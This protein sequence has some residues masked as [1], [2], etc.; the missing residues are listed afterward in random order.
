MA[1]EMKPEHIAAMDTNILFQKYTINEVKDT[2]KRVRSDIERKK[3]DLRQM[4]GERYRDLIEAADTIR[5]MKNSANN[6][7]QAVS[8]MDKYCQQLQ[9]NKKNHARE[10]MEAAKKKEHDAF[11]SIAA[12]IKLLLDMPER[13]WSSLEADELLSAARLYLLSHHIMSSLHLD[14]PSPPPSAQSLLAFFPILSRQWSYISHFKVAILQNAR[15]MLKKPDATEKATAEAL[16]S[17]V[18]LEDTSPRQVFTEYLLAK[19]NTIQQ[20]C[21]PGQQGGSI[22]AHVCGVVQLIVSTVR[23]MHAVFYS[24]EAGSFKEQACDQLLTTLHSVSGDGAASV[25]SLLEPELRNRPF[26]KHIPSSIAGF[27]PSL[28]TLANP[29]SQEHLQASCQQ[30]IT[31]CVETIHRGVG[32]LL[33]YVSTIKGLV[34]IRDAVW[35]MLAQDGAGTEWNEVCQHILHREVQVWEEFLRPILLNRSQVIIE[36]QCSSTAELS[37]QL[38]TNTLQELGQKNSTERTLMSEHDVAGYVWTEMSSDMPSRSSWFHNKTGEEMGGLAMKAKAFTPRVQSLCKKMDNKLESLLEDMSQ[39]TSV[40]RHQQDISAG[41]DSS[42]DSPP[43]DKFADNVHLEKYLQNGCASCV[44]RL[45]ECVSAELKSAR[46]V[47]LNK[48]AVGMSDSSSTIDKALFLARLCFGLVEICPNLQLCMMGKQLKD[49]AQDSARV[50][51]KQ[52][53]WR[54]VSKMQG[55]MPPLDEN[56]PWGKLR[57]QLFATAEIGHR[58]WAEHTSGWLVD[59]F[60]SALRDSSP[61]AL[62]MSATNWEEMEIQEETEAGKSVQ[63][64][65]RLPAQASWYVQSM[66][67][68]LCR[69]VNRVGGHALSRSII[70]EVVQQTCAGVL[71]AYEALLQ[72]SATLPQARALQLVFDLRYI[73]NMLS[74]RGPDSQAY[75]AQADRVMRLL[76]KIETHIDPFDLDVFTPH[77]SK[78]LDRLTQRCSVMLGVTTSPDRHLAAGRPPGSTGQQEQHNVLPLPPPI[79]R[80]SLLPINTR[81]DSSRLRQSIQV[82]VPKVQVLPSLSSS[83]SRDVEESGRLPRAASPSSLYSRIGAFSTGW[84]SNIGQG[85]K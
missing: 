56:S 48:T 8:S 55:T 82:P 75:R 37:L 18:L 24:P 61:A 27:C 20:L 45:L 79:P 32:E 66:L 60:S 49:G 64:K 78:A 80:F 73:T 84:L 4:V 65:I 36:S 14:S 42:T 70:H 6:V 25:Y 1:A 17:I 7:G 81:T 31:T 23:Q 11:Y 53:S 52:G 83:V 71:T 22:K 72:D 35:D 50:L 34:S 69:E 47:L 12:E 39:Y 13:I 41:G 10:N 68:L 57:S 38:V 9:K 44:T 51:H 43:F 62:L 54:G 59:Q 29:V 15:N 26:A 21:H 40:T 77:L 30:W 46:D 19:T 3:E 33:G 58:L 63:S 67:F 5:Q 76:E 16:C 28:K 2:E 85:N 74:A